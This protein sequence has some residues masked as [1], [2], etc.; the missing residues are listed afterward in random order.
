MVLAANEMGLNDHLNRKFVLKGS[1]DDVSKP[2][3]LINRVLKKLINPTA[4][5]RSN[6]NVESEDL[7]ASN[8]DIVYDI[9]SLVMALYPADD[10]TRQYYYGH[11]KELVNGE[12]GVLWGYKVYYFDDDDQTIKASDV[13][14]YLNS[15][16]TAFVLHPALKIND[17]G[18]AIALPEAKFYEA[19]ITATNYDVSDGCLETVD[20]KFGAS[21]RFD[22]IYIE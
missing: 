5:I 14:G 1:V 4:P 10:G 19:S 6:V 8:G 13:R 15:G 16:D 12:D 9:G 18:I 7:S 20:V 2:E 21:L 3:D 17:E 11:V 22:S